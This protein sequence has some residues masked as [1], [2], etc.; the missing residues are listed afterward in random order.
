MNVEDTNLHRFAHEAM[1]TTFEIVI[2]GETPEYARQASLAIFAEID[3]LELRLS[4]FDECSDIGQINRLKPGES[5]RIGI[6]TFQCLQMAQ[7]AHDLTDGAFDV[8]VGPVVNCWRHT[9]GKRR[10][11]TEDELERARSR[12]GMH[13]LLLDDGLD[14]EASELES[15]PRAFSVTLSEDAAA[16]ESVVVDLGGIGK[17]Y[18]LDKCAELL[19]DWGIDNA[20]LHGGTS[21]VLAIGTDGEHDGWPVGVAGE[22]GDAAGL[23]ATRLQ[24]QALSGSGIEIQGEHVIDPRSSKPT[25]TH[26]AAWVRCP[27]ATLADILSTAF[28]VMSID[29]IQNLCTEY[30]EIEALIPEQQDTASGLRR[31]GVWEPL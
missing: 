20:L 8:T 27:S 31:F 10:V 30:P 19:E 22:W 1:A 18:A 16:T 13:R 21:S 14:P 9:D 6:D 12:V 5:V 11:P 7:E 3:L 17:G 26:P 29:E 15:G 4:R 23:T 2:A 25:S 28:M 24:N